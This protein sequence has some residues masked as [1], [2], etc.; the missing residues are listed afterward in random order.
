MNNIINKTWSCKS[1]IVFVLLLGLALTGVARAINVKNPMEDHLDA[2]GY[3]IFDINN[4]DVDGELEVDSTNNTLNTSTTY[5]NVGIGLAATN[6]GKLSVYGEYGTLTIDGTDT[7]AIARF[8]SSLGGVIDCLGDLSG[9]TYIMQSLIDKDL[10]IG[11]RTSAGGSA[12]RVAID[13][14]ADR[15]VLMPFVYSDTVGGT[16]RD[17]YIDDTGK[18]GY[19]SSSRDVKKNIRDATNTDWIYD[20]RVVDFDYKDASLGVNQTGLIAEEVELIEPRIV[21]YK[22]N[23]TLVDA[24]KIELDPITREPVPIYE[25]ETIQTDIPETVN[26]GHPILI[27]SILKE[28]S[29]L[30]EENQM[31][32][33]EIAKLKEA[34]GIE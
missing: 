19:V 15:R 13:I 5:N 8:G 17:L 34:V 11:T 20:L 1:V 7:Y 4:L 16:N 28:M 14:K 9:H 23:E 21:S 29:N 25:V 27:G 32:K 18:L 2:A 30:R 6:W 22:I 33:D 31:L 26:Y 3:N 10:K 24:G 12:S